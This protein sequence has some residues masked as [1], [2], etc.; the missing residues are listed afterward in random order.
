M[1]Q[2]AIKVCIINGSSYRGFFA[3]VQARVELAE[4]CLRVVA[5]EGAVA[6]SFVGA[7]LATALHQE[8]GSG[9]SY[10]MARKGTLHAAATSN[11]FTRHATA[12]RLSS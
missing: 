9:W 3:R 5:L 10:A 11:S 8:L 2:K 1:R 12:I 4:A 6:I 7:S